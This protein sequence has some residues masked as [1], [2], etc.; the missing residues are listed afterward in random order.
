[1]RLSRQVVSTVE[2]ISK[3]YNDLA[4]E[5]LNDVRSRWFPDR[6]N[7]TLVIAEGDPTEQILWAAGQHDAGL[8]VMSSHGRGAIGRFARVRLPTGWFAMP[9]CRSW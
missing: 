6:E 1:M 4:T 5:Q 3:G 8:I 9:H 2:Q 7:V